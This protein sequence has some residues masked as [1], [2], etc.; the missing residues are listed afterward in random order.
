M[1]AHC[2]GP[3]YVPPWLDMGILRRRDCHR[4]WSVLS[5][6]SGPAG[7]PSASALDFEYDV[8]LIKLDGIQSRCHDMGALFCAVPP[9]EDDRREFAQHGDRA[10]E[11]R[12]E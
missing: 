8:G 10:L 6:R 5:F 3:S 2:S 9:D 4:F 12:A 11:R 1:L 7:T